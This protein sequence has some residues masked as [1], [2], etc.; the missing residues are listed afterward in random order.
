MLAIRLVP[1]AWSVGVAVGAAI[2]AMMFVRALHPPGGA[3]A[4]LMALNPAPALETGPLFALMPVGVTT[5]VLVLTAVLYNRATGRVY[6]FRQPKNDDAGE[7]APR[8]G[9]AELREAGTALARW[10]TREEQRAGLVRQVKRARE[11][12]AAR[13]AVLAEMAAG[14]WAAQMTPVALREALPVA[15]ELA[16]TL[17]QV[18][19]LDH[20][21]GRMEEA[22]ET[23]EAVAPRMREV[24]GPGTT[25]EALVRAA[26]QRR[27]QAER[28][29]TEI[30]VATKRRDDAATAVEDARTAQECAARRIAEL[31]A[32]QEMPDGVP[33]DQLVTKLVER[34]DL[35]RERQRA[36]AE[37]TETG[38]DLNAVRL[39]QEEAI[40]DPARR[41]GL[42][43]HLKRTEDA[44]AAADREAGAAQQELA[45]AL[46]AG[47]GAA[48]DQE[49]AL[50][51]EDLTGAAREAIVRAIGAAAARTALRRLGETRRGP[52]LSDTEAAFRRLTGGVWSRL[53][54]WV[55]GQDERLVGISEGRSVPADGMSTGTRA[56]LYLALRIAGH[57]A[58]VRD[59]GPLSSSVVQAMEKV[60]PRS[61]FA[62]TALTALRTTAPSRW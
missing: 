38:R 47:G 12:L 32:S 10:Q 48:A 11:R 50:I 28:V 39:D 17:D 51:L 56:Q 60:R 15:T 7:I 55:Q 21:I 16:K 23:F 30:A 41:A 34:D 42:A 33:L 46:K 29:A 52:M 45:S 35:R 22:L 2:A 44:S 58:F 53:D 19:E 36:E 54:T 31:L 13:K 6:P 8:L 49:R 18:R 1:G 40:L 61:A 43:D 37:I 57:A 62:S 20:R 3:V 14:N 5:T 27:T 26:R 4:L 9:L 24:V 25:A 59:A